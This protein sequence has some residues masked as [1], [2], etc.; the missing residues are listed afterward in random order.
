MAQ[1]LY[2]NGS[3]LSIKP[4]TVLSV[5]DSVVNNGEIR[6]DGTLIVSGTWINNN[7]YNAGQGELAL[8]SATL[9]VVN[10]NDQSFNRLSIAGGGEKIFQADI[11]IENELNLT[12]GV[13]L[14]A[15]NARIFINAGAVINGGS[16]DSF[17][18]GPVV[19][20]GE[21]EK[22][23]PI[24]FDDKYLPVTL[25]NATG[26]NPEIEFRVSEPNSNTQVAGAL[27]EVSDKRIWTMEVLAGTFNGSQIGLN[28]SVEGFSEPLAQWVVTEAASLQDPFRS[29]GQSSLTGNSAMGFIISEDEVSERL[30]TIGVVSEAPNNFISVI[31]AVS[32]NGDGMHDFLK[33]LNIESFPDNQIRIFNRWGDKVFELSG[34][35]NADNVFRGVGNVNDNHELLDGTYY[36]VID[37]GSGDKVNGF[38]VLRR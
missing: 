28:I 29:L 26:D 37:L 36:Y 31:N 24:G 22:H 21:G 13:L 17:I 15:D 20:R 32:P 4:N 38:L 27:K 33:I 14:S 12:E 34:Y 10:H 2:N 11:T 8:N 18:E 7:T 9:Q 30:F 1:S 16:S 5:G 25:L 19:H 23:F 35:D 3:L 6:N